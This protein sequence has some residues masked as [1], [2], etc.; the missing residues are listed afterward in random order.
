[1]RGVCQCRNERVEAG[2]ERPSAR[3][4]EVLDLE[5]HAHPRLAVLPEVRAQTEAAQPQGRTEPDLRGG[6]GVELLTVEVR[7]EQGAAPDGL[8]VVPPDLERELALAVR[9][10]RLRDLL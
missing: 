4:E 3:H 9:R 6:A 10:A 2:A 7:G 5:V 1:L 8:G